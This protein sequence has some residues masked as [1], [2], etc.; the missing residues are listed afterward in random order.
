MCQKLISVESKSYPNITVVCRR[1]HK[2]TTT[3][4]GNKVHKII[5]IDTF[6]FHENVFV[7]KGTLPVFSIFTPSYLFPHFHIE[8]C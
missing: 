6:K 3:K 7:N 2:I 1:K 5:F 4:N 8:L